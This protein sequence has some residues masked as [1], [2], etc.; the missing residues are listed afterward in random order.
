MTT[1]EL[2]QRSLPTPIG[3][4]RLLA[5]AP[6]GALVGAYFDEPGAP[7]R[8]PEDPDHRVLDQ[9][10]TQLREYF[11]GA[12]R[13]FDL[14]LAPEGTAFQ[15]RV[16]AALGEIGFGQTRSYG[17]IAAAIGRPSAS[18]AVGAA[19]GRNPLPVIVPCHRVIGSDGSLTGYAGGLARKRWLL[20]HEGALELELFATSASSAP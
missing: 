11:E 4:L 13:S 19:N 16:W 5:S 14:P 17:E 18:R 2:R 12:R 15:R 3:E 10:A 20:A 8:A 6:E 7:A 1:T 9:A